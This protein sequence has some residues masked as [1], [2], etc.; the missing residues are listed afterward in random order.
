MLRKELFLACVLL[1]GSSS[2]FAQSCILSWKDDSMLNKSL[3]EPVI[4]GKPFIVPAMTWR[5]LSA[6]APELVMPRYQWEWIKFPYPD[7]PFGAWN[8]GE[9]VFECTAP[10]LEMT[11]PSHT[12]KPRGWYKGKYTALPRQKPRFY[13]I[14]FKVT[15]ERDCSQTIFLEPSQLKKFKDHIA[16]LKRDCS[17][18]E[19]T[20]IKKKMNK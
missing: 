5:F 12:I 19:I 9:E 17:G 8:V 14:E 11:V 20:F 18:R 1:V 4:E 13:Q 6:K 7:R 10:S 3:G 15:W 2:N 16:V